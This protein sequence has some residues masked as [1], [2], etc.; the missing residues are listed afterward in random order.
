[1]MLSMG[2]TTP[3][4]AVVISTSTKAG[5]GFR[6]KHPNPSLHA[7]SSALSDHSHDRLDGAAPPP[8]LHSPCRHTSTSVFV[9]ILHRCP[10]AAPFTACTPLPMP[11][12]RLPFDRHMACS[13][14]LLAARTSRPPRSLPATARSPGRR[15]SLPAGAPPLPMPAARPSSTRD[16]HSPRVRQQP[17]SPPLHM[18]TGRTATSASVAAGRRPHRRALSGVSGGH[19][20]PD[21]P[22]KRGRSPAA[23]LLASRTGFR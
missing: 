15:A 22:E 1:M 8:R 6:P 12:V 4:G 19:A 5:E 16:R 2:K 13:A 20:C 18:R 21:P 23:T 11:R 3:E 9:A 17:T 10:R 14:L 7:P